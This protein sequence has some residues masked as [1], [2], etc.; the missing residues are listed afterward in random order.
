MLPLDCAVS[1]ARLKLR[2]AELCPLERSSNKKRFVARLELV[3]PVLRTL[4]FKYA[5][6]VDLV[7]IEDDFLWEDRVKRLSQVEIDRF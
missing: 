3:K 1:V 2:S 5:F 7:E 4:N 6:L